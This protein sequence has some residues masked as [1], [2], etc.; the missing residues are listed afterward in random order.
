MLRTGAG[1]VRQGKARRLESNMANVQR[2]QI[3][4]LSVV[5]G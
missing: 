2:G 1:I 4:L 5:F 3:N